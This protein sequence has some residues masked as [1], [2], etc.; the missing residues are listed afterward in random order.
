MKIIS[1]TLFIIIF[2][3]FLFVSYLSIFGIETNRFNSQISNK[4][5]NIHKDVHVELK[6]IKLVLD[7]FKLKLNI[8]TVGSILKSQNR[9]IELENIKT[10][11]SLK[12]LIENK[13]S[14]ESL[15]IST[16]SLEIKNLIS[17]IRSFQN[18]PELFVLEKVLK[19][20]FLIADFKLEFDQEGRIKD[21]Y[22]I[23]GFIKDTKLSIFKKYYVQKLNLTFKYQKD[24]LSL[25][26]IAF[27]L[28]GLNLVSEIISLK[29]VKDDFLVNGKISHKKLDIDNK[30]LSLFVKPFLSDIDLKKVR[31]SSKNNFS[32]KF[33]KK[34]KVTNLK[35]DSKVS[36]DEFSIVNKFK[37]NNFFPNIKENIDFL[38]HELSIKLDKNNLL[39]NGKGNILFQEQKDVLEYSIDKKKDNLDFKTILKIKNNILK[40]NFLNYEKD[41]KNEA[42][43]QLTGS[44]NKKDETLIK[45]FSV[46]ENK[47]KIKVE[48]LS[49]NKKYEVIKLGSIILDY[50]DKEKK[51]NKIKLYPIRNKYY[52]EGPFF[53]ANKLIN[54]L[55]FN[56]TNSNFFNID[57][58]INI[59]IKKMRVDDE[60]YLSNFNGKINFKKKQIVKADLI[61]DFSN[62]KKLKFTV[63]SFGDNK[64]SAIPCNDAKVNILVSK[65]NSFNLKSYIFNCEIDSSDFFEL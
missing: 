44:K 8:R 5:K 37:L 50:I 3:F 34:F 20:G 18:T 52:I 57:T 33:S 13:F 55:L 42:I 12:S 63:N 53:N 32:F 54:D 30:N 7:P 17:F 24:N 65:G 6:K 23:N 48:S 9:N 62:N 49:L 16:R 22:E 14:I 38:D 60:Y 45:S 2:V 25:N 26:D 28:N 21:N 31:L 19:K 29:K 64:I 59:K 40:I 51:K 11:I 27:S 43:I 35:L 15:E 41:K 10:Q 46:N 39:V 36:I 4:I 1:K 56:D 61:G 58:I 47:N